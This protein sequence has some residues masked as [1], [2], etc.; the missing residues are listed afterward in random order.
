MLW[1]QLDPILQEN[2]LVHLCLKETATHMHVNNAP[3]LKMHLR[4]SMWENVQL[5]KLGFFIRGKIL[6]I[7]E[8][9][10]KYSL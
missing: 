5:L 8:V 4:E 1:N 2:R 9:H 10:S 6:S 3:E 7:K